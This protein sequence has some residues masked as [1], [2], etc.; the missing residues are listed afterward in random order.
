M[1]AT[2]QSFSIPSAAQLVLLLLRTL[3]GKLRSILRPTAEPFAVEVEDI[4]SDDQRYGE[5]G[6]HE[7][8][9][10]KLPLGTGLDVG[11]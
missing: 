4:G 3:L 6:E 1:E 8:R 10:R 9:D 7:G 2:P 5:S 11:V